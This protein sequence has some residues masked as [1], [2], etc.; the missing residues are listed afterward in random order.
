MNKQH[1]TSKQ[2]RSIQ[3]N[4]TKLP[5]VPHTDAGYPSVSSAGEEVVNKDLP[6]LSVQIHH[7]GVRVCG[8]Q[9]QLG[10]PEQ[11]KPGGEGGC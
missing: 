5:D 2:R 9:V 7:V 8:V 6:T 3:N 4:K 11:L 1:D 10:S